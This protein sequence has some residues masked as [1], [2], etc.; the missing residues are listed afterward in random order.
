MN[1]KPIKTVHLPRDHISGL[2]QL[3]GP[4]VHKEGAMMWIW[5]HLCKLMTCYLW[6]RFKNHLNHLLSTFPDN[7]VIICFT[8]DPPYTTWYKIALATDLKIYG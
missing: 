6:G 4:Q 8:F 5:S 7:Q 2:A 3:C 1:S